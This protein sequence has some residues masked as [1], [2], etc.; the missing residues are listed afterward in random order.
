MAIGDDLTD[1]D[2]FRVLPDIAWSIKV[3]FSA[4]IAKFNLGSPGEVIDLLKQ[5]TRAKKPE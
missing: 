5:M 3:R 2:V 4:S 1:E